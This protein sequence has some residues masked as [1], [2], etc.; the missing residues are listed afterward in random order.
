MNVN[1]RQTFRT[2]KRGDVALAVNSR[3]QISDCTVDTSRL[4]TS[5][6]EEYVPSGTPGKP[7]KWEGKTTR[8]SIEDNA[9]MGA[10]A[11]KHA[12]SYTDTCLPANENRNT[13]CA[14]CCYGDSGPLTRKRG[15]S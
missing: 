15:D 7:G 2:V 4:R 14:P 1:T 6:A 8:A 12:A 3:R 5:Y 9:R 10:D 11:M 13:G